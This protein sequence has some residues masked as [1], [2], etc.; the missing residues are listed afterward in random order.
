MAENTVE[1]LIT[2]TVVGC[3]FRKENA[4]K[5]ING[6]H[7]HHSKQLENVWFRPEPDN[8]HDPSAIAVYYTERGKE[9]HIGYIKANET[10]KFQQFL[11]VYDSLE[12]THHYIWFLEFGKD[13]D[14]ALKW[15]EF[16]VQAYG[17]EI[18]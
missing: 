15:F 4:E 3:Q 17:K 2:G 10:S 18:E 16:K 14:G 8:P 6:P 1:L 13:D 12:D 5:F 11:D 9:Y 7:H